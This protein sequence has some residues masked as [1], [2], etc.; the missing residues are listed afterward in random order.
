MITRPLSVWKYYRHNRRKVNIVFVITFL[1]IFLQYA[2]L[3][4]ATTCVKTNIENQ[5][6]ILRKVAIVGLVKHTRQNRQALIQRLNQQSSVA[7]TMPFMLTDITMSGMGNGWLMFFKNPEFQPLMQTFQLSLIQGRL[8]RAGTREVVLHWRFAANKG[9]KIGDHFSG[10]LFLS[11]GLTTQQYQLT[12]LFD[13]QTMMG[14]ADLDQYFQ[15]YQFPEEKAG[16]LVIPQP[17]QLAQVKQVLERLNQKETIVATTSKVESTIRSEIN[18]IFREANTLILLITGIAT[19]CAGFLFYLYFYQRRTE[20][21]VLEALGHTKQRI[22][23]RAFSEILA[24]NLLAL[25]SA[26]GLSLIGGWAINHFLLAARGMELVLWDSGNL[27]K[28]CSTPL[29]VT[30]WSLMPVWRMIKKVDPVSIVEN[31]VELASDEAKTKHPLSTW[32]YF[33]HNQRRVGAVLSVI[34]LSSILQSAFLVYSTSAVRLSQRCE[35]E[36]WNV[37]AYAY[38]NLIKPS[39]EQWSHLRNT[40]A[41]HRSVARTIPYNCTKLTFNG[42]AGCSAYLLAVDAHEIPPIMQALHLKLVAGRLPAANSYEVLLHRQL[43]TNQRIKIGDRLTNDPKLRLVGLV[44]GEIILGLGNLKY[45]TNDLHN[46]KNDLPLLVIPQKNQFSELNHYLATLIQKEQNLM[47]STSAQRSSDVV[48]QINPF[49]IVYWTIATV[50]TLCVGFLFY[51]YFYQRRSEFGMLEAIGHTRP[52]I[53]DRVLREIFTLT[54]FGFGLGL[55]ITYL[56]NWALNSTELF[57]RNLPLILWDPSYPWE[58]L[59]LPLLIVFGSLIPV[60]RLLTKVD[61]IAMIE[62]AE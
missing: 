19:L 18:R 46:S 27:L 54:L 24:L 6:E 37:I 11:Y 25:G 15:D 30:C 48:D 12:G 26:L 39:S 38:P 5:L 34:F 13:G 52:M 62:G 21:G 22:I 32:N 36:L 17:G 56:V 41:H 51:L 58:L 14:F 57:K 53:I 42:I 10:K 47:A 9:L 1:S 35:A 3:I 4:F 61:P 8:P 2:L 20:I 16:V 49:I 55:T 7:R 44:D 31:N 50:V 43:A 33:R 59:S 23:G 60:W 29:F 45:L 40:L 28:L